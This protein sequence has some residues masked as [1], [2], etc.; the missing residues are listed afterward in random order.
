MLTL[1]QQGDRGA[2]YLGDAR[3]SA[4]PAGE[5]RLLNYA[6]DEKV[7]IERNTGTR[8]TIVKGT[9]AEG[10]MHVARLQRRTTTYRLSGAAATPRLVIEQLRQGS[11]AGHSPR[12]TM[13]SAP[14]A[15]IASPPRSTP[16]ATAP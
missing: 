14:P 11:G 5:K 13:S 10:V 15:P 12:R 6:V 7:A 16:R 8:Q 9:I 2:D 3:L 4:M 1:Y